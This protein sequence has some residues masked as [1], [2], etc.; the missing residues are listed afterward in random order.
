MRVFKLVSQNFKGVRAV[1]ITPDENF[2]VI[3]GKNGQGKSSV[4]DSI[5][6]ALAGRDA[7][8]DTDRPIRNGESKAYIQVDLGDIIVTRKFSGE[9]TKLEVTAKDGTKF[10]SP[11]TMLDSL[12]GRLSF[13]PFSY[14]NMDSKK[15]KEA[16]QELVGLD[17]TELDDKRKA[18]YEKRT[19]VNHDTKKLSGAL[20]ELAFDHLEDTPDE[21][22]SAADVLAEI[23]DA[24]RKQE[25]NAEIRKNYSSLR[26]EAA[27]VRDEIASIQAEINRLT[28]KLADKKEAYSELCEKGRAA[29]EAVN[30]LVDPDIEGLGNKLRNIESIN[31]TVRAKKEWLRMNRELEQSQQ[32][33]DQLTQEIESIDQAKQDT[34]QN[35]KFPIEGLSF[36]EDGVIYKDVPFKQCCASERLKVSMAMAM[37]LNPKL[38]VIRIVDGSLLDSENMQLIKSMAKEQD[39]QVWI[40]MVD[41]SGKMGIQIEDGQIKEMTATC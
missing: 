16:L 15:Q 39:Y 1:E 30:Q 36:N 11:Q 33:S 19:Q 40:E 20:Q 29:H 7:M 37:A 12:V 41:E 38:R 3:S 21:E 32:R 25:V 23:Q 31:K 24:Q 26:T 14:S 4:L 34:L 17:F 13:D 5:W 6:T 2:Q 28:D 35:A 27:E 10:S 8:K 22:V 9:S 18:L